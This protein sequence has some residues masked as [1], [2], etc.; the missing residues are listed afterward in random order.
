MST[1][2]TFRRTQEQRKCNSLPPFL[3]GKSNVKVCFYSVYS[4]AFVLLEN[5]LDPPM[6]QWSNYER[7]VNT[8]SA[9]ELAF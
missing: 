9:V 5:R 4:Y 6:R 7:F 2:T 8:L 1:W 3:A